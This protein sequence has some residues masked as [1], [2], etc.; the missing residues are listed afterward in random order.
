MNARVVHEQAG[1]RTF[2][3]VFDKDEEVIEAL[4]G[5]A[6]E[7]E[8]TAA[9]FSAIGAF[10]RATVGFFDR[11]R[12]DYRKIPLGEQVEV[13][14]L[15]GNIVL[16]GREPK[17]HAHV[18]L[19]KPDGTAHGGHL[20]EGHVWPTLEVVLTESP[21]HLRRREDPET[22]LTLIALDETG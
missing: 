13:L 12:K 14:S 5:F 6:R 20:L 19:G 1:Q 21:R 17:V 8:L 10:S 11:D 9:H 16:D 2:V 4:T 3:L 22:G 15:A 18:V 7:E